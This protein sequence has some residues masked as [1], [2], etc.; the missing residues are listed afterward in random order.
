[1][2]LTKEERRKQILAAATQLFVEKGYHD[3]R[4][5]EIA[6]ACSVTEPV[7]YKHFSSKEELFLEVIA[8]IAGETF[9]D[10]SFDSASDE[11]DILTSFVLNK[12]GRIDSNFQLF[13]RLLSELM[14][15]DKIRRDYYDRFLPRLAYPLVFYLDQLKAQKMIKK[16]IPSKVILLGLVGIMMVGSLAKNLEAKSAYSDIDSRELY[17]QMMH[18][19]LHGL[20]K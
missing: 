17:R 4:T 5:K 8:S 6:L 18:V 2:R 1:M 12:A 14:E 13:K 3:T 15:N 20:L 9:N 16:E 7:I 19:Y 11:E 10:I